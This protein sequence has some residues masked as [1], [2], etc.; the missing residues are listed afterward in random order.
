MVG[1]A[2]PE[3]AKYLGKEL[4]ADVACFSRNLHSQLTPQIQSAKSYHAA[5][6]S[7]NTP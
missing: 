6:S 7:T 1:A 4:L 5:S 3:V 2:R